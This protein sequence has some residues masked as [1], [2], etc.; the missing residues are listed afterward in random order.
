LNHAFCYKTETFRC[1]LGVTFVLLAI[2]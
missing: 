1:D 2:L